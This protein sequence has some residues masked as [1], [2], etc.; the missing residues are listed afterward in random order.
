V[1]QYVE[2]YVLILKCQKC[3][4]PAH[5]EA[6]DILLKTRVSECLQTEV[7]NFAYIQIIIYGV[8]INNVLFCI[9]T[10]IATIIKLWSFM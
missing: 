4:P 2:K 1:F 6:K 3:M 8:S 5:T 7:Q 10:N 9:I